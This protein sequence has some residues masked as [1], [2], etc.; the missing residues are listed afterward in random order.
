MAHKILIVDDE[1]D[2]ESLVRQKFRRQVREG[3]YELAFAQNG[4]L[5][6]EKL[7]EDE[8]I[9]MVLSDINMPVMDGLT[10]LAKVEALN[11]GLKTVIVSAYG[12][13]KNIRTAMN[14]G[15]FDF[16]TK[17]VDYEDLE[18]TIEKTLQE[19]EGIK[20]AQRE[21]QQL[22]SI[23]QELSVA[24]RIQLSLMPNNFPAFPERKD[25]DLFAAMVP[26]KEVGGDFYD[27]FL[28]DDDRLAII[29]G[30]VSGK[31][32]PAAIFMAVVRTLLRGA[33]L[34]KLPAGECLTYVNSA[35]TRQS[36]SGMFVTIFYAVLNTKTGELEYSSAGHNPPYL[37]SA[38]G[39]RMLEFPRAPVLGIIDGVTYG[40]HRAQF[41]NG[42]GI[43]MY[44]DGVTEAAS[45]ADRIEYE[46]FSEK[47]VEACLR[48]NCT[49]SVPDLVQALFSSIRAYVGEA[50][51]SDDI[52]VLAARYLG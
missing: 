8:S 44:T 35:L 2:L 32:V 49:A 25:F 1:P 9:G 39:P 31:G 40:T 37:L 30:D 28:I 26:A 52:T 33:S 4:K 10:L 21:R 45:L 42:D 17:P 29:I 22:V 24:A 46:F 3:R 13:M 18:I 16:V 38:A 12:D 47:R 36:D 11:R 27:F 51:Q 41:E 34:L 15:A 50:P 23:Q 48:E 6:L 7:A 20:R 5:A 19:I 14:R 43:L